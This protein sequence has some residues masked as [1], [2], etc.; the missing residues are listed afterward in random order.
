MKRLNYTVSGVKVRH[1]NYMEAFQH[2]PGLTGK[3]SETN[4]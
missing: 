2:P 3:E 1:E 4:R